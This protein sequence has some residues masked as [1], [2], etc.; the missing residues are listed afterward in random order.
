MNFDIDLMPLDPTSFLPFIG[1]YA[2]THFKFW[3]PFS[4]IFRREPELIFDTPWRLEPGQT[5]TIFLVIK[6][7]HEYPVNLIEVEISVH[8][9]GNLISNERWELD[10]TIQKSLTQIEFCLSHQLPNGEVLIKP[11]LKYSVNN[12]ILVMEVDNYPQIEKLPLRIWVADEELPSI[13]GWVSGDTHLH[14]SLTMDQIEFGASLDQTRKCAKLFG[15]DFITATDHS[16]DLDDHLDDYTRND[17][18]LTKWKESRNLIQKMNSPE[19]LTIIP[20][21]EISVANSK[22]ATVHLLHYNDN[23]FFPGSGDSGDDWPN[24]KS[25]LTIDEVLTNRSS[26]TVSVGA[27][28]AYKFPWLQ[29]TLLNRGFW[30]ENDHDNPKLDGVQVLCG[31]PASSDF[32]DSRALWIEALLRGN[33][34]SVYG[35]SDGHG[36]FNRNWHVKMPAWALGIHEDQIFGQVRSL[37]RADSNKLSDLMQAMQT[38]RSALSTGPVG[39]MTVT[40]KNRDERFGIGDSLSTNK[41]QELDVHFSGVCSKEFGA[42][43]DVTLYLGQIASEDE[44]ICYRETDLDDNFEKHFSFTVDGKSYLRYELTSEGSRW[45]GVYMSSPIWIN[46]LEQAASAI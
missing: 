19:A 44:T 11:I 23:E 45:P 26:N 18:D 36:N 31:T 15:L 24:L 38:G 33:K 41:G 7:A 34:L 29:R 10:Q 27:H 20:G 37:L 43:M 13:S 35:G 40:L 25:E 12:K 2:E 14:T 5:P 30:G 8:Q 17:P 39:D 16:Y 3:V 1:L 42:T 46:I 22:G 6:D 32:H 9:G 4:R 21:E 28:T